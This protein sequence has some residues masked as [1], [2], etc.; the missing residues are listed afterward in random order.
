MIQYAKLVESI[1]E[2]IAKYQEENFEHNDAAVCIAVK[3]C[4]PDAA[5][6]LGIAL[7]STVPYYAGNNSDTERIVCKNARPVSLQHLA[8]ALV[9]KK[10]YEKNGQNNK[11]IISADID[12]HLLECG[13][14]EMCAICMP[15]SSGDIELP[16]WALVFI[17]VSD[18]STIGATSRRAVHAGMSALKEYV[19]SAVQGNELFVNP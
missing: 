1:S 11:L 3:A 8:L 14:V 10:L 6:K 13:D 5:E 18:I 19:R 9:D 2:A 16:C 15:G 4:T 7:D 12:D 17:A